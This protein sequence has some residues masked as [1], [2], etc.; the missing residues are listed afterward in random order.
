MKILVPFLAILAACGVPGL[1]QAAPYQ[2][3]LA[4][5]AGQTYTDVRAVT[6]LDIKA[7]SN[8]NPNPKPVPVRSG[9]CAFMR[10]WD[11]TETLADLVVPQN[12]ALASTRSALTVTFRLQNPDGS[13]APEAVALGGAKAVAWTLF[14][15]NGAFSAESFTFSYATRQVVQTQ[16]KQQ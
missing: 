16:T 15:E 5:A 10:V 6:G 1:A 8:Q 3:S 14:A 4:G 12:T 7:L 2:V 13:L 11:G 9:P